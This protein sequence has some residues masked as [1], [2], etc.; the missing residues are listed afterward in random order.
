MRQSSLASA[1]NMM[2][3]AGLQAL[4]A[5]QRAETVVCPKRVFDMC[6][7]ATFASGDDDVT[8]QES[9]IGS[10]REY[11]NIHGAITAQCSDFSSDQIVS[12]IVKAVLAVYGLAE[13]EA[14][15]QPGMAV[16]TML[17]AKE[18][19]AIKE[20]CSIRVNGTLANGD[21]ASARDKEWS[22]AQTSPLKWL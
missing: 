12:E 2:A 13:L 19:N 7:F 22:M 4:G 14:M 11:L 9:D 6:P 16:G 5:T 15:C 20:W 17:K 1:D 10:A 18:L 21:M 8:L 3:A